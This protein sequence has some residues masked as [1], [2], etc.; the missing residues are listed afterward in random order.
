MKKC[1]RLIAISF[2]LISFQLYACQLNTDTGV[3]CCEMEQLEE[4]DLKRLRCDFPGERVSV[5]RKAAIPWRGF[6]PTIS[7]FRQ[8]IRNAPT[9][10][11]CLEHNAYYTAFGGIVTIEQRIQEFTKLC[12]TWLAVMFEQLKINHAWHSNNSTDQAFPPDDF[13][14]ITSSNFIPYAQKKISRPGDKFY[15]RGDLHGD[16][17]SLVKQL[18]DMKERKVIDDNF[19][20]ISDNIWMIFLGDYVDRGCYGCEVMYILLRLVLANPDRV[21]LVRGNHEDYAMHKM[22]NFEKEVAAK[23]GLNYKQVYACFVRMYACMPVVLYIGCANADNTRVHYL[24][25]CHGGL[26]IGY[27]PGSFL[28]CL[29]SNYQRIKLKERRLFIERV[30]K[31]SAT[32]PDKAADLQKQERWNPSIKKL[33][34]LLDREL[35]K[36]SIQPSQIG[37]MWNDFTVLD[38]TSQVEQSERGNGTFTYGREATEDVLDAQST[39]RSKIIGVFRGHQHGDPEMMDRLLQCKGVYKLWNDANLQDM[40]SPDTRDIVSCP[41]VEHHDHNKANVFTFNVAP[42][43]PTG[44]DHH[45]YFDTYGILTIDQEPCL[46]SLEVFNTQVLRPIKGQC[47]TK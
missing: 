3:S 8:A 32:S 2:F 39:Q 35:L 23:F 47:N 11:A 37:F 42:D 14:N 18:E 41:M 29:Y 45:F 5:T 46:W 13:F 21:I 27:D 33:F 38:K 6:F 9:N 15:F 34:E 24:Q 44:V 1:L 22:Y 26:E 10:A 19:R 20:I 30:L 17:L 43:T 25:G 28:D 12:M 40:V 7:S 31:E 16:I 4:L 36:P